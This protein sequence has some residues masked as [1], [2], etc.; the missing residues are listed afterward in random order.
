MAWWHGADISAR[1]I[2]WTLENASSSTSVLFRL[3]MDQFVYQVGTT[4]KEFL[5]TKA[6]RKDLERVL[7]LREGFPVVD[8]VVDLTSACKGKML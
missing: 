1:D 6:H 5:N 4:P 8:F 7:L 3:V 2:I